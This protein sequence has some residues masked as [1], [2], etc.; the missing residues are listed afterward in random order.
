M[1]AHA[2]AHALAPPQLLVPDMQCSRCVHW[3][4]AALKHAD[5]VLDATVS[6]TSHTAYVFT[7]G[8]L[9]ALLRASAAAGYSA[10]LA[11]SGPGKEANAAGDACA[12]QVRVPAPLDQPPTADASVEAATLL[13]VR[14][15][16]CAACASTVERA[17]RRVRGVAS[18]SASVLAG[19][20]AVTWRAPRP[21]RGGTP[22][23]VAAA[24][25]AAGD[26]AL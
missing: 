9:G 2:F 4:K 15:L 20:L 18:A 19:T 23:D 17:A 13:R 3:V 26:A 10:S 14:G 5:G 22:D 25:R 21:T 16:S 1:F 24:V 11:A 6:L 8:P 7:R 12:L